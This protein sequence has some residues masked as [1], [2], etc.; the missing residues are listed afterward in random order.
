M[1]EPGGWWLPGQRAHADAKVHAAQQQRHPS[2]RRQQPGAGACSSQ[3]PEARAG[4]GRGG[5]GRSL[6]AWRPPGD[7]SAPFLA[8]HKPPNAPL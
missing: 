1:A 7:K 6:F 2:S 8:K 4:S 3:G 5:A